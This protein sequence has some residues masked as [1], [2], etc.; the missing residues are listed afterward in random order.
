MVICN[1]VII[2]SAVLLSLCLCCWSLFSVAFVVLLFLVIDIFSYLLVSSALTFLYE[3]GVAT[4]TNC[5]SSVFTCFLNSH[6]KHP[7]FP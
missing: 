1:I 3:A 2:I 6:N 5:F 7:L 4:V